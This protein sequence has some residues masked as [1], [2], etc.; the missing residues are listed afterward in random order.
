MITRANLKSCPGKFNVYREWVI[1]DP[2]TG[3]VIYTVTFNWIE[4]LK[5][6]FQVTFLQILKLYLKLSST[7][8]V[9]WPWTD[10]ARKLWTQY[11]L[12]YFSIELCNFSIQL[13]W[14]F[15]VESFYYQMNSSFR[16][17]IF[18]DHID[19]IGV[20]YVAFD[21]AHCKQ[22]LNNLLRCSPCYSVKRNTAYPIAWDCLIFVI[23]WQTFSLTAVT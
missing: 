7:R 3:H 23:L 4:R 20:T 21:S 14:D 1:V 11:F 5:S 10:I 8:A 2:V 6:F 22:T 16:L 17:C 12:W 18:Y 19:L 9:C 15:S 13:L